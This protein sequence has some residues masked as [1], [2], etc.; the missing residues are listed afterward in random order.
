MTLELTLPPDV[1]N[2]L[3]REAELRRQPT[4]LVAIHL[5][6]QHL[7]LMDESILKINSASSLKE[8]F[9]AANAIPESDD[10]YD[11]LQALDENR[12]GERPLFPPE[13]KGVSW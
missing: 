5:L 11:L 3:R 2:R 10:G 1:E 6:D 12:R 4:E 7:P 13:L 9:E 8:L